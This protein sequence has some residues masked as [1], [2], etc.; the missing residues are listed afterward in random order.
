MQINTIANQRPE[1]P[2]SDLSIKINQAYTKLYEEAQIGNYIEIHPFT[3]IFASGLINL[4]LS[5]LLITSK[6]MVVE[7]VVIR[8]EIISSD[9]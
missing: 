2:P 9:P 3:P 1:P 7:I 5:S 6:R 4:T 8:A